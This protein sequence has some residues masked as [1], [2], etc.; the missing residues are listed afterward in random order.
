M[1]QRWESDLEEDLQNVDLNL[2]IGTYGQ[3]GIYEDG[4]AYSRI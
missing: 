2:A 1:A 3:N 4:M